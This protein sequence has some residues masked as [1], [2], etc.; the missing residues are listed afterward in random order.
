MGEQVLRL[1]EVARKLGVSVGT[2]QRMRVRGE[3]PPARRIGRRAR[4][5]LTSELDAWIAQRP[6]SIPGRQENR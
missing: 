2:V 4:G 6:L 5:W 3:L 1:R